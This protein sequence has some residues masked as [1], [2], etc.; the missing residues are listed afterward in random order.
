[1]WW[2]FSIC[3]IIF[4]YEKWHR[5]PLSASSL[6]GS[7]CLQLFASPVC[8]RGGGHDKGL[9]LVIIAGCVIPATCQRGGLENGVHDVRVCCR[10]RGGD[11]KI[12]FQQICTGAVVS[13]GLWLRKTNEWRSWA[14][15]FYIVG[16]LEG[17]GNAFLWRI[18]KLT[19]V[20]CSAS[21]AAPCVW[22]GE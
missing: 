7:L 16:D 18:W 12:R 10:R 20:W 21:R 22:D 1:M 13:L 4:S 8:V 19:L 11:G 15:I 17:V 5:N 9:H 6:S 14:T 2:L 3:P